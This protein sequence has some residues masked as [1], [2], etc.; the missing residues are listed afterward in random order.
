VVF[1]WLKNIL[2]NRWLALLAVISLSLQFQVWGFSFQARG[3]EGYLLAEWVM[4]ISL[5]GYVLSDN[6]RW[7]P[8]NV[9]SC[10]IGFFCLPSF[11]YFFLA[12]W[13]FLLLYQLVYKSKNFLIWKCQLI[14]LGLTY[15]FYL[16]V[17][18]FSGLEAIT[19]NSYVASMGGFRNKSKIA[20]AQWMFPYFKTYMVHLFSDL[21]WNNLPV[22]FILYFLPALLLI[23]R[24]DKAGAA[25]G[26]F[27]ICM[28]ITFFLVV[29]IMK[30]LPFERNLIGHYGIALAGVLLAAYYLS[31][32]LAST[33]RRLWVKMVFFTGIALFF[34]VHFLRTN[35]MMLK[36]TLY[37]YDVNSYYKD[38]TDWLRNIPAGSTI[39]FSDEDFYSYYVCQQNGYKVSKCV[40]GKEEY[41]VKEA[42]EEIPQNGAGKYVLY[43]KLYGNEIWQ[44]K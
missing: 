21:K 27:Y 35:E 42:F 38:K 31:D 32:W 10:A 25:F 28:W 40:T 13:M 11:L 17:L 3:Y 16:P 37:E 2:K 41:Y 1:F 20:F 6:R 24:K 36:D 44:L 39:A 7:L 43:R 34:S 23:K 8:V 9:I 15:L 12:Q 29:I 26:L 4:V 22:S 5:F 19:S 30:K 14:T 18:C 33:G